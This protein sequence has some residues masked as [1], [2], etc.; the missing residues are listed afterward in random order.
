MLTSNQAKVKARRR[1]MLN[2]E[3]IQEL[4]HRCKANADRLIAQ[5]LAKNKSKSAR[6]DSC[7]SNPKTATDNRRGRPP[8]QFQNPFFGFLGKTSDVERY[9]HFSADIMEGIARLDW[10]DRSI[11]QGG[12]SKPL[13]LR[14]L[15][16]ILENLEAIT[17][18][19]V[20]NLL[21]IQAR[22]SQRYVKAIE[23]AMPYLMKSRPP[24]LIY[25]M[26]LP[27]D[28]PV[29]AE[30]QRN[31]LDAA[32]VIESQSVTPTH[33]ELAILRRDLGDDAFAPGYLINAAYYKETT[34]DIPTLCTEIAA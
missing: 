31:R 15:M 8:K 5:R 21:D 16:L 33:E 30:R 24:S 7:I 26:D 27:D 14:S 10:H 25:K 9:P 17:S 2:P 1:K 23:L 19:G 4:S 11:G 34:V 13:S 18:S 20:G 32:P 22:H 28:E 12:S 3:E 29:S 6:S